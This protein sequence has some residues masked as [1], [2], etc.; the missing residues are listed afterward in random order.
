MKRFFYWFCGIIAL[1]ALMVVIGTAMET[2]VS[3]CA[4]DGR[5]WDEEQKRCFYDCP[6]FAEIEG[7]I[8]QEGDI[9]EKCRG[10]IDKYSKCDFVRFQTVI[11]Y[12]RMYMP[13][14][15]K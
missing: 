4:D 7:C 5:V 11:S 9:L 10:R 14:E 13:Y 1:F 15:R 12:N 8:W 3:M 6:K 2:E